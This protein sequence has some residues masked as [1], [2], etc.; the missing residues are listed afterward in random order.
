MLA[1]RETLSAI[2]KLAV[3][4][5]APF[6]GRLVEV[7]D[8]RPS[9]SADDLLNDDMQSAINARLASRLDNFEPRAALSIWAKW[10][11]NVFL[12]PIL[13]A[14]VLLQVKLPVSLHRLTFVIGNDSRVAA[15]KIKGEIEGAPNA[16]PFD[17]FE[18]LVFDHFQPLIE[19]LSARS[20][21]ARRVLWSNVGN[22]FEAMLRKIED[23]SGKSGRLDQASWLLGQ[24]RWRDGRKNPLYAHVVYVSKGDA[25][26]RRRRVCCLQYRASNQK[27]C[28]ACPIE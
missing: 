14:D 15:I 8:T 25:F 10:Y 20:K 4:E 7:G 5:F 1:M 13:L 16:D 27:F 2:D 28:E 6:A 9:V 21:L 12:P 24:P 26:T 3:G 11:N 18:G 19:I 22:T 17:R 23:V